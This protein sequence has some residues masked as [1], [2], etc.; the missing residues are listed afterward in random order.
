MRCKHYPFCVET[1]TTDGLEEM[2]IFLSEQCV[3]DDSNYA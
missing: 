3:I 1:G 2:L